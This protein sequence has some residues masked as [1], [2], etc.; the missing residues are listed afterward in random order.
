MT[1][2]QWEPGY[3][4][5]LPDFKDKLQNGTLKYSKQL[6]P[7][8]YYAVASSDNNFADDRKIDLA[9]GACLDIVDVAKHLK[10]ANKSYL[11]AVLMH[12]Y[13]MK[14][15]LVVEN[16]ILD[17]YN[18]G[19]H[20]VYVDGI[21]DFVTRFY[22]K[23]DPLSGS[24]SAD[25]KEN[26]L[27]QP[28]GCLIFLNPDNS[29]FCAIPCLRDDKVAP[30]LNMSSNYYQAAAT[31]DQIKAILKPVPLVCID[32]IYPFVMH[33]AHIN[34]MSLNQQVDVYRAYCHFTR[35]SDL[36]LVTYSGVNDNSSLKGYKTIGSYSGLVK[37]YLDKCKF[38]LDENNPQSFSAYLNMVDRYK[39][40][41]LHV[42]ELH[43]N[44]TAYYLKR[45]CSFGFDDDGNIAVK[46]DIP[47]P[48]VTKILNHHFRTQLDTIRYWSVME[49]TTFVDRAYVNVANYVY[50]E[51]VH[52]PYNWMT[53]KAVE[54]AEVTSI[55]INLPTTLTN[56]QKASIQPLSHNDGLSDALLSLSGKTQK[57]YYY[58][59]KL[60]T[61]NRTN[62]NYLNKTM[63]I[64]GI[65]GEL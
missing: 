14:K 45:H 5:W 15:I 44:Y 24:H 63:E 64:E 8:A 10:L 55:D 26:V 36:F 17:K 43:E 53:I 21:S 30:D 54:P 19:Y 52:H 42:I 57:Y 1:E 58:N 13:Y 23:I 22:D 49:L 18:L 9:L 3:T 7:I 47:V 20:V 61:F 48:N 40:V 27:E 38:H 31:V 2:Q 28:A 51:I 37:Y 50:N 60:I 32:H 16:D 65:V 4:R 11:E 33:Y 29:Y 35:R 6:K 41:I 56:S 46:F 25:L 59:Q 62:A 39:D 12:K 34:N